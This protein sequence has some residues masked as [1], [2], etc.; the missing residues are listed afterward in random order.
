[1]GAAVAANVAATLA[2]KPLPKPAQPEPPQPA[3][4]PAAAGPAGAPR[5]QQA[6][7]AVPVQQQREAMVAYARQ[8]QE[9]GAVL[10]VKVWQVNVAGVLVQGDRIAGG[11]TA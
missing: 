10:E 3:P 1:M 2:N 9:S 7:P 6:R 5:A 11:A 4:A 8:C